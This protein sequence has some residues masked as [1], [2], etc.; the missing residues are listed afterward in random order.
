VRPAGETLGI[1]VGA[2]DDQRQ[3]REAKGE[4][5]QHPGGKEKQGRSRDGEP[6]NELAGQ[7]PGGQGADR[8]ARIQRVNVGI[9]EALKAMAA[10]RAAIMATQIIPGCAAVECRWRR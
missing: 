10:E 1:G 8:S 6:E 4:G 2:D 5:I 3:R 7:Q 9:H